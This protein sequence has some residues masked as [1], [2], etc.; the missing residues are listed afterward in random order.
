MKIPSEQ[1]NVSSKVVDQEVK[2][3]LEDHRN[4]AEVLLASKEDLEKRSKALEDEVLEITK[5]CA[6]FGVYLEENAMTPFNDITIS[7]L[8]MLLREEKSKL[9]PKQST[10]D[11]LERVRKLYERQKDICGKEL[12]DLDPEKMEELAQKLCSL[13]HNGESLQKILEQIKET[14]DHRFSKIPSEPTILIPVSFSR[15]EDIL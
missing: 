8:E 15:Y 9:F 1:Q 14:K 6:Q 7:N 2:T 13:K 10:I 11:S 4:K 3:L 5:V 12:T